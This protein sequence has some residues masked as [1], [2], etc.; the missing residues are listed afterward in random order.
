MGEGAAMRRLI[1][2]VALAVGV[3]ACSSE[4]VVKTGADMRAVALGLPTRSERD[5]Q[6]DALASVNRFSETLTISSGTQAG[7]AQFQATGF[8]DGRMEFISQNRQSVVMNGPILVATK[9]FS[10]DV[11]GVERPPLQFDADIRFQ[12]KSRLSNGLG[13]RRLVIHDCE[14]RL[15]LLTTQQIAGRQQQVL[16]GFV[17]CNRPNERF[18]NIYYMDPTSR[19]VLRSR[20]YVSASTGYV[21]IE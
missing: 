15:G 21:F 7:T 18:T 11:S 4:Q 16:P 9:G 3:S 5:L 8:R 19:V 6:A 12:R 20:Q 10:G 2:I 13:Q 14:T 1:G 17:Q